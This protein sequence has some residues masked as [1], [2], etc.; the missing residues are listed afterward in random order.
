MAKRQLARVKL[1]SRAQPREH[2]WA[3]ASVEW[4]DGTVREGWLRLGS[5]SR[6]T[7]SVSAEVARRLLHGEVR[8]EAYTPA[9]L[10]G[11]SLAQA[12]GGAFFT[13]PSVDPGQ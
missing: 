6:F 11:H 10:F 8:P 2:S 4:P 7:A 12:C 3:H 9:A 13:D 1:T 5:A